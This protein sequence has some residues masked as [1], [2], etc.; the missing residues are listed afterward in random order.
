MEK[1]MRP[2]S[3]IFVYILWVTLLSGLP[4]KT[5]SALSASPS[6]TE[7]RA[8]SSKVART[9]QRP[10]PLKIHQTHIESVGKNG[11]LN[12]QML[13]A[14]LIQQ[15][16]LSKKLNTD[17][18]LI[19]EEG[20]SP[21]YASPHTLQG[22]TADQV[23]FVSYDP[24]CLGLGEKHRNYKL[25]LVIKKF[26]DKPDQEEEIYDLHELQESP[27]VRQLGAIGNA[28]Y[29]TLSF[30]ESYHTYRDVRGKDWYLAILH[31]AKGEALW[32][33]YLDYL[34]SLDKEDEATSKLLNASHI[35]QTFGR[36]LAD[37]H[38]KFMKDPKCPFTP[39]YVGQELQKCKTIIQ[40]DLNPKN[41]FSHD[42]HITFIDNASMAES[43]TVP[44]L[45]TADVAYP[46]VMLA[47]WDRSLHLSPHQK[48]YKTRYF[49]TIFSAFLDGYLEV[50]KKHNQNMIS[51]FAQY[52]FAQTHNILINLMRDSDLTPTS[53]YLNPI[54]KA[55]S[56]FIRGRSASSDAVRKRK[57]EE[58]KS[59]GAS[60]GI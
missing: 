24:F 38:L 22:A 40:G 56:P 10:R 43:L 20:K 32:T 2:V 4:F 49:N 42:E 8:S 5:L 1:L 28:T 19:I 59:Y 53:F 18:C 30:S 23:F 51:P 37:F 36:L 14:W 12:A 33:I 15:N 57:K 16:L 48:A 52:L 6:P 39:P 25:A 44:Q 21:D 11:R 35:Y 31:A 41:V 58:K 54:K 45:V 50:Y 55:F 29:P 17:K 3:G 13:L 60:D 26:R 7:H 47:L 9:I 46:Y 34:S 27:P